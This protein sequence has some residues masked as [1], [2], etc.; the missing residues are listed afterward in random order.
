MQL[1]SKLHCCRYETPTT[2]LMLLLPF[3]ALFHFYLLTCSF[4]IPLSSGQLSIN[5]M[6][7]LDQPSSLEHY[8]NKI[9]TTPTNSDDSRVQNRKYES[10]PTRSGETY[11]L[12]MSSVSAAF[13][14]LLLREIRALEKETRY[15]TNNNDSKSIVSPSARCVTLRGFP[16]RNFRHWRK[17]GRGKGEEGGGTH[18]DTTTHNTQ[19]FIKLKERKQKWTSNK[20]NLEKYNH[21]PV[22]DK[23]QKNK[24]KKPTNMF[25]FLL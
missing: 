14:W 25:I 24:K 8:K 13:P 23:N 2:H 16:R 21:P 1:H 11:L 19:T 18:K 9:K 10:Q 12:T 7:V 5:H 22:N 15:A 20:I 17:V 3:V 6:G 4:P